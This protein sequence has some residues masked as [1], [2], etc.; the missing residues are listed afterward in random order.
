MTIYLCNLY[1][2]DPTI[3]V[4]IGVYILKEAYVIIKETA[5]ILMEGAPQDLSIDEIGSAIE[6]IP[7]VRNI[8]HVH[9]WSVGEHDN[10]LEAHIDVDDMMVS[11]ADK[12]RAQE[13]Q[14]PHEKFNIGHVTLQIENDYC[15]DTGLIKQ[16]SCAQP[17]LV[18]L[19]IYFKTGSSLFRVG[20]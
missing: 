14:I 2:L 10:H 1:W 17:T 12:I 15:P 8:H 7:G 20:S 16:S 4:L 18:G 13:E 19:K 5:H 3:T 9:A 11:K 6:E